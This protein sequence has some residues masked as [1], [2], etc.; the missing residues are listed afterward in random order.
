MH[1]N[2]WEWSK[3]ANFHSLKYWLIW[4]SLCTCWLVVLDTAYSWLCKMP[5]CF[6]FPHAP[7][8]LSNL[9]NKQKIKKPFYI[10]DDVDNTANHVFFVSPSRIRV[11]CHILIHHHIF[12]NLIL[13]FIILSSISLATEDPIR[14]HSFRNN[15]SFLLT[16]K[17]HHK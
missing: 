7:H 13:V 5:L 9:E 16:R 2:V 8:D 11:G 4:Y 12:T 10:L 14:A 1:D 17:Q 15:V 6:M 3:C